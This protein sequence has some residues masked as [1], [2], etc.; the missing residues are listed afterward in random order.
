M[1]K[2]IAILNQKGGVG[3]TTIAAHL[4]YAL[5]KAGYS[6]LLID[7][8]PQGS[9][10]DWSAAS[11]GELL[12]VIGLDRETL[13]KDV[14]AMKG[15]YDFVVIDGRAKAERIAGA[16]IRAADLVLIPVAPSALD[17][18]GASDLVDAIQA[19]H[20][21]TEG[22]PQTFFLINLAREGTRLKGEVVEAVEGNGFKTLNVVLHLREIYRQ[23]MGEGQTVY[24]SKNAGAIREIDAL[25][26]EVMELLK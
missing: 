25:T 13:A 17:V 3:K 7:S 12:S 22:N 15:G 9:L 11:E 18:W 23:T 16:A 8:D 20:E 10:R 26:G 5:H 4:A 2:V 24:Q 6:V 21:V 1:A 14:E 19:R